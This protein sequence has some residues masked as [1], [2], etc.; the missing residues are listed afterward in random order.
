MLAQFARRNLGHVREI[1]AVAL[2]D[3]PQTEAFD[4]FA[5]WTYKTVEFGAG[6]LDSHFCCALGSAF[7]IALPSTGLL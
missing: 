5:V 7:G 2:A 4:G 6:L 1:E 3:V